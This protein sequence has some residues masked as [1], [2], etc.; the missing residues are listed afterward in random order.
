MPLL[1]VEPSRAECASL[2]PEG[3]LDPICGETQCLSLAAEIDY[4]RPAIETA[5][6]LP[7][8]AAEGRVGTRINE[9]AISQWHNRHDG[10]VGRCELLALAATGL[11]PSSDRDV[12]SLSLVPSA[13]QQ[14]SIRGPGDCGEASS[15]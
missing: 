13:G 10:V 8:V 9:P 14:S 5:L 11:R 2:E 12:A 1:R 15:Y 4:I 3:D 7:V 6:Q